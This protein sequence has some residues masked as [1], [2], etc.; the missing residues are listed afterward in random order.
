VTDVIKR[1]QG[2]RPGGFNLAELLVVV[3]ILGVMS[4][5]AVTALRPMFRASRTS[6]QHQDARILQSAEEA[7]LARGDTNTYATVTQLVAARFLR[8]PSQVN[9]ICLKPGPG[10]DYFVV[11]GVPARP[12]AGDATCRAVAFKLAKPD[13]DL[14][15]A[16][17]GIRAVP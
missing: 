9:S 11:P 15:R 6:M 5:I 14:Y 3:V 12:A 17:A 8:R 1:I 7:Y 13:P 4:A 2:K 16:S 10:G